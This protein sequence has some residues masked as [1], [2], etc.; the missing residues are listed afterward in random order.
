MPKGATLSGNTL[1]V[2]PNFTE[3]AIKKIFQN[4]KVTDKDG[5]AGITSVSIADNKI[6]VTYYGTNGKDS[7]KTVSS[8]ATYTLVISA[9]AA[10]FPQTLGDNNSIVAGNTDFFPQ[11]FALQIPLNDG[12]T[13]TPTEIL[14]NSQKVSKT[15][16][17]HIPETY[18]L[19][20]KVKKADKTLQ[21]EYTLT[22]NYKEALPIA[23]A[24][25][26]AFTRLGLKSKKIFPATGTGTDIWSEKGKNA[27]PN[28]YFEWLEAINNFSSKLK[29]RIENKMRESTN[30][31]EADEVTDTSLNIDME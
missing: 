20:L 19:T 31:F 4:G 18:T 15:H 6:T 8:T 30:F 25:E 29:K 14:V 3:A 13:V 22:V 21:Q 17:I 27:M 1:T 16:T 26:D 2:T 12:T 5:K 28:N 9:I 11:L 7:S 23:T 24:Q 10:E